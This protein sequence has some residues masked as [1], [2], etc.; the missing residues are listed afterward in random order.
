VLIASRGFL[1]RHGR[2]A[3]PT[4]AA[5]MPTIGYGT[6]QGPHLWKLVDPEE[7]EIRFGTSRS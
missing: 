1:E 3:T 7:R 4:E 2:P 6:L 5:R